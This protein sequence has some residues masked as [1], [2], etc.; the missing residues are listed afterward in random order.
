MK[1]SA[2]FVSSQKKEMQVVDLQKQEI[3][4][5]DLSW[6]DQGLANLVIELGVERIVQEGSFLLG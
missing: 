4:M 6:I 2:K 1:K 3:W 5:K